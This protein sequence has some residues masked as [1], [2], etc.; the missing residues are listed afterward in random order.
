M[1]A[2]F[3]I[4]MAKPP[5]N[6][7]VKLLK[8]SSLSLI[9][10]RKHYTNFDKKANTAKNAGNRI[11]STNEIFDNLVFLKTNWSKVTAALIII[12]Y[13]TLTKKPWKAFVTQSGLL[14]LQWEVFLRSSIEIS[15]T[16]SIGFSSLGEISYTA[17]K[18]FRLIK[19]YLEF[20]Q[21]FLTVVSGDLQHQ[22]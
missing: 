19:I 14:C 11:W 2:S 15:F 3:C 18:S 7:A 9:L 13:L 5:M 16:K 6:P 12:P 10:R 4:R 8:P 21:Y 1:A 17:N 22:S 20:H